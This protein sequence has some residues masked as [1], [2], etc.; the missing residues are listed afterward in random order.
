[1]NQVCVVSFQRRRVLVLTG[2]GLKIL[3]PREL[4]VLYGGYIAEM[5]SDGHK[6]ML[7]SCIIRTMYFSRRWTD[8]TSTVR[9]KI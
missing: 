2:Y 5:G 8:V 6:P 1:M 4:K 7:R 9:S 3:V